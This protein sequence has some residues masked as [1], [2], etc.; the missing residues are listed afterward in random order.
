MEYLTVDVD[1]RRITIPESIKHLGVESDDETR[2]LYWKMPRYYK[3]L[4]L[5]EFEYYINYLNAAGNGDVYMVGDKEVTD[6]DEITFS[7]LVGRTAYEKKGDVYFIV[8]LKKT[9]EDGI[10]IQEWN[11]T[12]AKLV[13]LEGLETTEK[14]IQDNL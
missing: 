12:P 1:T 5:S 14:I 9:N 8:C 4:D 7:W 6:D 10:V 3:G 11:T 13:I 2:R